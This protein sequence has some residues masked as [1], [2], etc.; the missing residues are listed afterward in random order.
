MPLIINILRDIKVELFI[1]E[2]CIR[3]FFFLSYI[4]IMDEGM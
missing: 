1:E 3:D 2:I 4:S